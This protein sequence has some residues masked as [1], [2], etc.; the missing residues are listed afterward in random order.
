MKK[1]MLISI[2]LIIILLLS[3][4]APISQA[5][6]ADV[7]D[8]EEQVSDVTLTLNSALYNGI[9]DNLD[10]LNIEGIYNV[11]DAQRTF[12]ITPEAV[13]QVTELRLSN[14][15]IS[16]LTGIG[17][18]K[19]VTDLDL[20]AN[21]LSE[22]SHLDELNSMTGLTKLDLSSNAIS[23]LSSI[24][25]N[26]L[27]NVTNLNLHNQKFKQV[28]FVTL[29]VS[30]QS[31]EQ[32]YMDFPM[33]EIMQWGTNIETSWIYDY[34]D[35]RDPN[36]TPNT[37]SIAWASFRPDNPTT[38]RVN[39]AE[40]TDD[41]YRPYYGMVKVEFKVTDQTSRL[42][43]SDIKLYY[44]IVSSNE[45]GIEFKDEHLYW[46]IKNQLTKDQSINTLIKDSTDIRNLYQEETSDYY[47]DD[48]L[49]L[50]I[51]IDDL[52]NKINS[53]MLQDQA[54]RDLTGLEAF[55][56]IERNLSIEGN[57][58]T[59]VDTI[60][61]LKD[62]K[63]TEEAILQAKVRSYITEISADVNKIE[64][65]KAKLKALDKS[66]EEQR[67]SIE[68]T[69]TD[70]DHGIPKLQEN[71][72]TEQGKITDANNSDIEQ[73][74]I[75]AAQQAIVDDC[76]TQL[77]TIDTEIAGYD[78]EI[79]AADA[80]ISS[81]A[82]QI[83]ALEVEKSGYDQTMIE[84]N[85]II[86]SPT[87]T[88]E[89]KAAAQ[90]AY[91]AASTSSMLVGNQIASLNNQKSS[92]ETERTG[93]M[94]LKSQAQQRRDALV[95]S[96]QDAT[97][98]IAEANGVKAAN[99]T[100]RTQAQ[101]K[102]AE[103]EAEIERLNRL[104][105]NEYTIEGENDPYKSAKEKL[106]SNAHERDEAQTELA[107]G[108]AALQADMSKL[109][110]AYEK[111]Y[112]LT[113]IATPELELMTQEDYDKKDYNAIKSLVSA[114]L[115]RLANMEDG[116]AD[117]EKNFIISSMGIP[118]TTVNAQTGEVKEIEKPISAYVSKMMTIMPYKE[119]TR[120]DWVAWLKTYQEWS[121]MFELINYCQL[122]RLVYGKTNCEAHKLLEYELDKAQWNEDTLRY[123][124]LARMLDNDFD[125]TSGNAPVADEPLVPV[126]TMQSYGAS[127]SG[128]LTSY[129]DDEGNDNTYHLAYAISRHAS[130]VE[131]H[132][133][134]PRLEHLNLRRNKLQNLNRFDELPE[135]KYL[136]LGKNELVDISYVDWT[137][138]TDLRHLDLSYN[139]LSNV[140]PLEVLS[141]LRLLDLSRNL[142][143]G[144][145]DFD[146][147]G[148]EKLNRLDFSNNQ[149][150]DISLL[151]TQIAFKAKGDRTGN[152]TY[153]EV[154]Q[155]LKD[156]KF[157]VRFWNQHLETK[158]KLVKLGTTTK[159]ELPPI[160]SQ[161]V[162]LDYM[163][164]SFDVE[165]RTGII[166]EE[167]KYMLL[168]TSEYGDY[169]A[170]A[171]IIDTQNVMDYDDFYDV[172]KKS[173]AAP[174]SIG[175]GTSI[176]ID[177][178]VVDKIEEEPSNPDPTDPD[179][180]NPDPVVEKPG[181]TIDKIVD[182]NV[183]KA[184]VVVTYSN[185]IKSITFTHNGEGY[186]VTGLNDRTV[187]SF[188]IPL[189]EGL[190]TI[191]VTAVGTDDV[192]NTV[193]KEITV[194]STEP[195]NPDPDEDPPIYIGTNITSDVYVVD[196][197]TDEIYR[198]SPKTTVATFKQNL[199]GN[200]RVT[201]KQENVSG[202]T[203][204]VTSGYVK[205]GMLAVVTD[206]NGATVA[207]YEIAV[208]GDINGDGL[209]NAVDSY[210][211]RAAR[212][213]AQNVSL[214]NIQ[215]R[216]ADINND[217]NINAIDQKLLL[218]HRAEVPGYIL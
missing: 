91:N 129:T 198:V 44:V 62:R 122:Y 216:A 90:L 146:I 183:A 113:L 89:E 170:K 95:R 114:Q 41:A 218:F 202:G 178:S 88:E 132:V 215:T 188:D 193:T 53:L 3:Y 42:Y 97:T 82:T 166:E 93:L 187:A 143:S 84:Q 124:L 55:V 23:D 61:D 189:V 214:T 182:N 16:D 92:K 21:D 173:L 206:S 177:Y 184:H 68:K 158:L 47:Y 80:V 46:A 14:Y 190:N 45:R 145:Y 79:A 98:K 85:A 32:T 141:T 76:D 77:G 43:N 9:K 126:T 208:K 109:C 139:D 195:T 131:T 19:Y 171:Y 159:V 39:V 180:V 217:N 50:V 31:N 121:K 27:N 211:L 72:Q 172:Y 48:A 110:K 105:A 181:I 144:P 100:K 168:D 130:D 30:Q 123:N 155:Y 54:I 56:G 10:A 67:N 117:W 199:K 148:M 151:K 179:P 116:L 37:P 33:P 138:F 153:R 34:S 81:L 152:I 108:R 86:N 1:K 119:Y 96:K 191:S 212:I 58:I 164:S 71:I 20:S 57:L 17:A 201:V 28:N 120:G 213:E 142:I 29:D 111:T 128:R 175:S 197:E 63:V 154:A 8:D 204:E 40:R 49:V 176:T 15:G 133:K 150:T 65:A 136:Y 169:V 60:I 101:A 7:L 64:A 102:I 161:V 203:T 78:T 75:I 210:I 22:R 4:I 194:S 185:G 5:L 149:I 112:K 59:G 2:T 66:D 99:E 35:P 137:V 106:N 25:S 163:R 51:S 127:C 186:N 38:I 167:G 103:Y 11:N 12:S 13:E 147:T 174:N 18:F 24:D 115:S 205:T 200:Y 52:I 135:L 73:N 36:P 6:A 209:A 160:F 156:G 83:S 69:R 70:K 87:A 104:A 118:T 140:K 125:P 134:I 192:S 94:G 162:Q 165:S 74:A 207:V 196:T 157:D 26:I 107:Q